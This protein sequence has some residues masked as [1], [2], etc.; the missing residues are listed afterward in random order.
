MNWKTIPGIV[1]ILVGAL[2][3]V[4]VNQFH[5]RSYPLIAHSICSCPIIVGSLLMNKERKIKKKNK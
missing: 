2:L 3:F 4:N 5:H 1:L